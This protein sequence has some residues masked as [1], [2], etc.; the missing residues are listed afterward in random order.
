VIGNQT[1]LDL[2]TPCVRDAVGR[3][4]ENGT[5]AILE[6]SGPN[7]DVNLRVERPGHHPVTTVV[8]SRKE[9]EDGSYKAN[10]KPRVFHALR[11]PERS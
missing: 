4:G 3:V 2:L 5:S 11:P 7:G 8:A 9:I 10:F 1:L 6:I